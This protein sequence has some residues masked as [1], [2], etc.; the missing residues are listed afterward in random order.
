MA[1]II[2][3][4]VDLLVVLFSLLHLAVVLVVLVQ[5]RFALRAV[6]EG[7]RKRPI[8]FA[9]TQFDLSHRFVGLLPDAQGAQLVR[10]QNRTH[11][12][13]RHAHLSPSLDARQEQV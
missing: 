3:T 5:V 4:V 11:I 9:A 12:G 1:F 2:Q 8:R 7:P 13:S 6:A 10:Q